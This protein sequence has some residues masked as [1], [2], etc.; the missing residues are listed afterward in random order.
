MKPVVN[1]NIPRIFGSWEKSLTGLGY[2]KLKDIAILFIFIIL[3][4]TYK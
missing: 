1:K 2:L 4:F 3:F